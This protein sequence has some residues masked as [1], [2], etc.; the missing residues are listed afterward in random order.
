MASFEVS[1]KKVLAEADVI[2]DETFE[3]EQ[4]EKHILK[5]LRKYKHHVDCSGNVGWYNIEKFVTREMKKQENGHAD[6]SL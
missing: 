5:L 1:D 3:T 2:I 4:L 6:E